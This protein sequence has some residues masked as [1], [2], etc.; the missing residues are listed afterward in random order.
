MHHQVLWACYCM[1]HQ[2]LSWLGMYHSVSFGVRLYAAPSHLETHVPV[3]ELL[4]EVQ[5]PRRHRVQPARE[6]KH[7]ILFKSN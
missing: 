2:V 4:R 5:Q 3:G 1:Q 7:K 6:H